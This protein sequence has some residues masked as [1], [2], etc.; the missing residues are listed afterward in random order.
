MLQGERIILRPF[1]EDDF[2]AWYRLTAFNVEV[3]VNGNGTWMPQTIEAARARWRSLYEAFPSDERINF[4]VESDGRF[5]GTVALKHID[6]RSQ[7]AW[8]AIMLDGE[9]LGRGYGRDVLRTLLRW[10]FVIENF[11]RIS[12]ETWATNERALR[13]YQAVGFVEEGRMREAAWIAGHYVDVVQM[14]V[15]RHEWLESQPGS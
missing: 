15:L 4:A 8:L 14:G 12:L 2:D 9:Q 1:R 13:C 5:I 6:R 10:A 7:H 3:C 11:H